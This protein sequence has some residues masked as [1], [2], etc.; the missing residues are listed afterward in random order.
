MPVPPFVD[1]TG[2]RIVIP[3]FTVLATSSASPLPT[4]PS[5]PPPEAFDTAK[6]GTSQSILPLTVD[7]S[8]FRL[9]SAFNATS[10]RPFDVTSVFRPPGSNPP[11][12]PIRPLIVSTS[13]RPC[14]PSMVTR[15]LVVTS[16]AEPSNVSTA[17][18]PLLVWA[19][20]S[21]LTLSICM[22][23]FDVLTV[24]PSSVPRSS[25]G[26]LL[27]ARSTPVETGTVTSMLA[28]LP[29]PKRPCRKPP[30]LRLGLALHPD[31]V[32]FLHGGVLDTVGVAQLRPHSNRTGLAGVDAHAAVEAA[33]LETR[34][35]AHLEDVVTGGS[36][37]F[38]VHHDGDLLSDAVPY[39]IGE[40]VAEPFEGFQAPF[41][42]VLHAV[43]QVAAAVER[44]Q[45]TLGIIDG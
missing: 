30:D 23:A 37:V 19:L 36:L 25:T 6:S 26:L 10:M 32:A 15:P 31:Q 13:N 3:P 27:V 45:E 9:G 7:A 38:L 34:L 17:M 5:S 11:W 44:L 24:P 39:L 43:L 35:L 40:G 29:C 22:R 12:N 21:P 8:T 2:Y 18:R 14:P 1:T 41:H 4:R 28:P 33:N 20:R 42:R 16:S